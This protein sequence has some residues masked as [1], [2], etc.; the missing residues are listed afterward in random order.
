MADHRRA[1][2]GMGLGSIPEHRDLTHGFFGIGN[3]R[4]DQRPG[5]CQLFGQQRHPRLFVEGSIT[6]TGRRRF[7]QLTDGAFMNIGVLAQIDGSKE[8]TEVVRRADQC[9]QT[10]ARDDL[11]AV[12]LKGSTNHIQFI[13]EILR[14]GIG[15]SRP[16]RLAA[17]DITVKLR[18]RG[19]KARIDSGNGKAIRLSLAMRRGIG[20]SRRQLQEFGRRLDQLL[21]ERK[22]TAERMG[23]LQVELHN[24]TGML[25]HGFTQNIGRN[26]RVAVAV[27]ANPAAHPQERADL[28]A[29]LFGIER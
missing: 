29:L 22:L 15:F 4:R 23:F 13:D 24:P 14:F 21:R 3:E 28:D 5:R 11:R 9:P 2:Q 18:R 12:F 1:E 20:R 19:G 16:Q 25:P 17:A 7:E 8:E 27:A 6:G 10:A 26:E